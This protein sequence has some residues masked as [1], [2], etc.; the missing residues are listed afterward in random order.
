M[1]LTKSGAGGVLVRHDDQWYAVDRVDGF[2]GTSRACDLLTGD[3]PARLAGALDRAVGSLRPVPVDLAGAPTVADG[4]ADIW[5]AGLN[6]RKHSQDLETTQPTSGPGS[7]LRPNGCLIDNGAHIELPTRSERITAE[8]ELGLV[9]GTGAK[10]VRRED[11]RS[12]VA[13]V[14]TV[15]DMTAEDVIREN[16]RHIPWAKGFDTFCSIGPVLVTVDEFTDA[17]L[18]GLRVSTVRN[19]ETIASATPADMMYDIGF[20]VEYF[21]A[22]RTLRPGTVICTG[23][24]GAAVIRT[25]DLVEAV[26]DGVGALSHPVK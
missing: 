21:S 24:P 2:A 15:L 6:Y 14:T 16:P 1:R 9:L 7:Y 25:G 20:L 13:A 26:V 23:T 17:D 22:G 4:G 18:A 12:V 5:G 10:D 19:G 8:A 3:R 11:W